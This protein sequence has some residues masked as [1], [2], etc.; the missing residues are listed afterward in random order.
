MAETKKFFTIE[1]A[2]GILRVYTR[3]II[4]YIEAGWLKVLNLGV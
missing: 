3:N 2:A 1:E 4:R